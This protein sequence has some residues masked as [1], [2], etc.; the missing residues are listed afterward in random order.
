MQLRRASRGFTL[1]ELAVVMVII[2]FLM[3]GGMMTFNAQVEQRNYDETQRRLNAAVEAVLAF[4]VVNRRLPCPAVPAATGVESL[5]SGSMA[6][7]GNCTTNFGGFLPGET[8]GFTQIDSDRYGVDA[9]NNRVR[10]A[11]S[12]AVTGCA[13]AVTNPHFTSVANLRANGIACRPNDLDVCTSAACTARVVSTQ[14]AAFIV[15]SP[16]KNGAL[17]GDYGADEQ[18]NANGT[19][20]FVSRTPG[21]ASMVGGQ[22]DD[23][24]VVVPVGMVYSRLIA[25]GVLP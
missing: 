23:I 16:G 12:A 11:V 7:G 10:Y 2:G 8:I 5:S 4:A 9:Y 15:W 1:T 21:T 17:L 18:E 14:T 6:A 13:G 3:I 24:V 22:F 20:L 19:A 25:A